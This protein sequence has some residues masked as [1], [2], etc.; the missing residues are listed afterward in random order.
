MVKWRGG[1]WRGGNV[2]EQ[3]GGIWLREVRVHASG[4]WGERCGGA[5]HI[6]VVLCLHII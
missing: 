4:V 1:I 6:E 3:H 5:L 2:E